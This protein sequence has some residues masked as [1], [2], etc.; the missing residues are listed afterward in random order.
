VYYYRARWYDP[1]ARRFISEDPI[2]LNGGINLYAYVEN[3]PVSYIDPMGLG[4]LPANPSG[5]GP[6]WVQDFSH[7]DPNGSKWVDPNG[8]TLEFAKG[9]P[10]FPKWRGKDHWHV[11]GDHSKDGH[12]NP[13]DEVPFDTDECPK[14]KED[15]QVRSTQ[16][17][18]SKMNWLQRFYSAMTERDSFGMLRSDKDGKFLYNL[19]TGE[20]WSLEDYLMINGTT[21]SPIMTPT[22]IPFSMGAG[23]GVGVGAGDLIFGGVAP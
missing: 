3:S 10:G 2:G 9:R 8:N 23:E 12:R 11:N 17:R 16:A 21:V 20:R 6:Q 19:R 14:D 22:T 1:Q 18:W 5:L 15:K 4:K 13:G 7:Q